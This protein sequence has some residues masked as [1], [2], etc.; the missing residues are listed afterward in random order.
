LASR[1]LVER[2]LNDGRLI[3]PVLETLKGEQNF[4][5]LAPRYD[6]SVAARKVSNWLKKYT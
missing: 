1:F 5:L 6:Q 4:Y 2:D 3:Q